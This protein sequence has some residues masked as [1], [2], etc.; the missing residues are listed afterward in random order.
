VTTGTGS[1]KTECFLYP[2][3]DHCLREKKKGQNGIKAIILY[4]MN[5]LASDQEKRFT[6]TVLTDPDLTAAGIRIGNYTGR[7]NP[8]DPGGAR[9]SG[10]QSMDGQGNIFHGIS[11]HRVLQEFPPDI[12][13]TNYRMLDF[14]LSW[15]ALK[16]INS[17]LN[18]RMKPHAF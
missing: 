11:N 15:F 13:L 16:Q 6:E 12:L 2:I 7:Y 4:P 10:T 5:A 18:P 9:E 17:L 1:G 14:L 8:S 3:L